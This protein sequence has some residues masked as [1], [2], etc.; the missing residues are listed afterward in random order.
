[1]LKNYLKITVRNLRK[2]KWYSLI[3]IFGLTIGIT[4][5]LIIYL[6]IAQ[7]LSYDRFH[8][9]ADRIY[10]VTWSSQETSGKTYGPTVPCPL[11]SELKTGF[12]Q[13]E[14]STQIHVD[15][16]PP[17]SH[18][19]DRFIVEDVVFADSNFVDVFDFEVVTGNMKKSFG[20]PNYCFLSESM[21][22]KIFGADN[23]VGGKLTLRGKLEVEVVGIFRDV[24]VSSHI[25]FDILVSYP[26]LSREYFRHF[27]TSWAVSSGYAYVVLK[28]DASVDVTDREFKALLKKHF[29]EENAKKQSFHLQPLT[30]IYYDPQWN[31]NA[32]DMGILYSLSLIGALILF[33][34]CVNFIN[35]TTASA[36]K[37]AKEVGVRKTL[38]ATKKSLIIQQLADTLVITLG[39]GFLALAL[40][41]RVTPFFHQYFGKALAFDFAEDTHILVFL[42][43]LILLVTLIAGLYPA[44]VLSRYNPVKALK[45]NV[46]TQNRA[47]LDI[48]KGLIVFQ[49]I[50]SQILI[51]CTVIVAGQMDYFMT[52]SLGFDKEGIITLELNLADKVFLEQFEERVMNN[53]YVNKLS[54]AFSPP[55]S[56]GG[57]YTNYFLTSEGEESSHSIVLSAVDF[58]YLDTYDIDLKY[59]RWFQPS[60][61]NYSIDVSKE[62]RDQMK[63]LDGAFVL[64]EAAVK[65]LGFT[66]PDK[67]LGKTIIVG[68]GE[69]KGTI[70]GVLEDFH[71]SSL[72]EEIAP[73]VMINMPWVAYNDN[74][75][76]RYNAGIKIDMSNAQEAI[77]HVESVFKD[78]FPD[79]VFEYEFLDDKI[80]EMYENE[81]KTQDVLQ[82]FST[83]S[84]VISCMGLLGMISF[85]VNQR[86]KEV[87][88]R[89][90][91]G[92]KVSG[93]VLLFSKDFLKLVFLAA[94]ISVPVAWYVMNL[95]L[96]DFAY[97][98]DMQVW[99]F[100]LAI[101]LSAL[102]T[103]FTIG[104]QSF[105]AAIANPVTALKDE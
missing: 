99:F 21:A 72:H 2:N 105:R 38:G 54:I 18:G 36:I 88:I 80:A 81:R 94:I 42:S 83:L 103:F 58:E 29:D 77:S 97:K 1:M 67:A 85:I 75:L 51:V 47:S 23:P 96:A 39:S 4:G 31:A 74:L 44:F 12:S 95:W 37:K 100:L 45:S 50:I 8:S 66:S 101:C 87:G 33:I 78:M 46:H 71:V 32:L 86:T 27:S 68:L 82:L 25:Q 60:E 55:L 56:G 62:K 53:N 102:I 69:F 70:V 64:N 49:F 24:P 5:A 89:K 15:N 65:E 13:F 84:I 98:I 43:V 91:L 14:N 104:Y 63:Q 40:I 52:K 10:R 7:E 11:I 20:A 30:E 9:K 28:P 16:D 90:V 93:I 17:V 6:Y 19:Q 35:L 73:V 34:A 57:I 92:A 26:S 22:T 3:N 79:K 59:G 61:G 48:R 41:E 76:F